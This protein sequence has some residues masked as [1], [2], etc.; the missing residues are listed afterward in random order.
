MAVLHRGG[1]VE[2]GPADRIC[3]G[4]KH[5]YTAAL[6]AAIPPVTTTREAERP[7]VAIRDDEAGLAGGSSG[8]RFRN[9]CPFAMDICATTDPPPYRAADGVVTYC[10]LH[11]NGPVLAGRSVLEE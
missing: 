1:R 10:H 5:P 9:R 2:V 4:P 7:G 6:L 3:H 8:C 11:T